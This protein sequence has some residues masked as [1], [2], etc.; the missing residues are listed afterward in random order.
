MARFLYRPT[1]WIAKVPQL[2][3]SDV[4]TYPQPWFPRYPQL[5]LDTYISLHTHMLPKSPQARF[6][7]IPTCCQSL[8]RPDFSTYP[9]VAKVSP[10][11]ISLHTHVAKVSPGPISLHTHMLPKSPQEELS[12]FSTYPHVAKVSPGR[13]ARFLYIPTCCQS[14]PRYSCLISLHT[15]MLPKFSQ[16]ELPDFSTYPHVA[17]VFPGR[18]A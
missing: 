17:K 5:E 18:V 10:G 14:L 8:A 7:Y 15:H 4:L 6:L 3:R 13:V 2:E 9:H 1:A 16:V 11:P 12:D